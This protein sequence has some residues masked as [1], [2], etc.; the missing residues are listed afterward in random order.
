MH[1]HSEFHLDRRA[2]ASAGRMSD[3]N[4]YMFPELGVEGLNVEIQW[5]CHLYPCLHVTEHG[6]L[7]ELPY[8]YGDCASA[9]FVLPE[10]DH[11]QV[12]NH[13][14]WKIKHVF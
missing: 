14:Q 8:E 9:N 7:P 2:D 11:Y 10:S 12:R 6:F 13:L 1:T 5:F 4:L 3:V